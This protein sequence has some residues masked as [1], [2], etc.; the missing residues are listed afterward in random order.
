M[1]L[2]ISPT[3][4]CYDDYANSLASKYKKS[5]SP[6]N[7]CRRDRGL[8]V[9]RLTDI[10]RHADRL[11]ALYLQ[12]HERA[13]VRPVTISPG[14]VPALAAAL[15]DAF[16][17]SVVR[18]DDEILGF[19]TTL[20]DGD[21]AVGYLIGLDYS[22]NAEIPVYLRLLHSVVADAIA[23]GCRRLSLGRTA[24]EP[25]ARLGARPVPFRIWLRHRQ[26]VLNFLVRSLLGVIPHAEAPERNPFRA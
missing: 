22:V 21:T 7:R 5:R 24:L 14:Y 2:E 20:R 3:W 19:V 16:R 10:D 25:K 9:E 11:H 15:G 8:R 13:A 6:N 26:P 4:R 18:R 23:L 1:V 17:C 12:V